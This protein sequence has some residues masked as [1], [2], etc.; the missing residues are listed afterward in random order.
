[1]KRLSDGISKTAALGEDVATSRF[2]PDRRAVIAGG[3]T[4]LATLLTPRSARA[5]TITVTDILG[6]TVSV[7]TPVQRMILG[8]GRQVFIVGAL[9]RQEPFGRVVGWRNDLIDTDPD[10]WSRYRSRYPVAEKLPLFNGMHDG[11]F[12]VERAIALK[13]DVIFLNL[14]TRVA[15]EEADLIARL[16]A[17]DMP[18]VYIDFREKPFVNTDLS[19]RLFGRL[20]DRETVAEDLI[21][22]RAAE[23]AR[24]TD[25]LAQA[26]DIKR[27]LVMID[28][29]PG[30]SDECCLSFGPENFGRMVEMAGGR[31]LG[32]KIIPG[33]FGTLNPEAV[34]TADPDV[35]ISTAGNFSAYQPNG[36]WVDV[37][38]GADPA[39]AR[40]K[41]TALMQRPAFAGTKAVREGR[42]HAI[43]HQFYNNPYQFV[44]IQR[45]A[46]WLHPTLFA[47]LDPE[48][49]FRDLHERF[50]PV[51]YEPGYW[52]SLD[53]K[54]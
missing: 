31:N 2:T 26:G 5:G 35:V 24:V 42:V 43:W 41:L 14:E 32:S 10:T 33:T 54:A 16:G 20:L 49:T 18:V 30:Y 8:E 9:D 37:G 46:K 50:L 53:G 23:I 45:I 29:I 48:A 51:P 6:R 40:A 15:G 4:G 28:R 52:V 12:D 27:P 25:R 36:A 44:A 38:P 47:D 7:K 22:F 34:L 17:L 1:M 13:P 21:A 39:Q 11:V 3:L 19:I